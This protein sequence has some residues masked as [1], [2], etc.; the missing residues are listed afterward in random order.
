VKY[1]LIADSLKKTGWSWGCISAIGAES[2]R[3]SNE[4]GEQKCEEE[5]NDV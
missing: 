2:R 4:S 1:W 5:A 3:D